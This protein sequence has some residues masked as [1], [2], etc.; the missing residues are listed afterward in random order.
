MLISVRMF[1]QTL[2]NN[3]SRRVDLGCYRPQ[4]IISIHFGSFAL[5]AFSKV[6][7]LIAAETTLNLLSRCEPN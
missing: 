4:T 2:G 5:V 1:P 3:E 6:M 7:D